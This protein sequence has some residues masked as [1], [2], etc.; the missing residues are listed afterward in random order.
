MAKTLIGVFDDKTSAQ[1]AVRALQAEG[2]PTN[3]IQLMDNSQAA[4]APKD[5]IPWTERIANWFDSL[6]DDDDDKV[7]ASHYAEAWRRGHY[8]VV[9]DVESFMVDRAVTVMNANGAV[10][11]K[12]RAEQWKNTGYTGAFDRAANPYTPEQRTRELGAYQ[13]QPMAGQLANQQTT[14]QNLAE[15][16]AIPVVQEELAVGKRIVQRGGVRVHS[17]VQERPVE[18]QLRL[19]EERIKVQRV[20]VNRPATAADMAFRERT[21]DMKAMGEEPVVEKRARVVEEVIVGKEVEHREQTIKE[22]VRRKDVQ[23]EALP[24]AA[25]STPVSTT[26][27]TKTGNGPRSVRTQNTQPE[28]RR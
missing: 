5:D 23:V 20:P 22:T 1:N 28:S 8:I 7:H 16:Q 14:S 27:T 11:I 17:Y 15:Q 18:E 12:R 21:V 3:H 2:V 19:R 4:E 9:A 25:T 10:D 13:T 24:N 6:F 26:T